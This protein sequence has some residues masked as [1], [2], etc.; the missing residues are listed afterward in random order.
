MMNAHRF[1]TILRVAIAVT[2]GTVVL[3]ARVASAAPACDPEVL[4]AAAAAIAEACPCDGQTNPAGEVVPWRNHGQYVSC[5]ARE[6]NRLA[7]DLVISKS[8]LR[9]AVPCGARSTCGKPGVVTCR[10]PDECSDPLADGTPEG[11][12]ADDPSIVCDTAAD[13]PVLRCSIKSSAESCA[14]RGGISGT[15][16]CCD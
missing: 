12:C 6:R 11:V 13:C 5:V 8:C 10:L 9:R 2:L 14:E 7:K 16:S 15:G 4:E 1:G 3:G